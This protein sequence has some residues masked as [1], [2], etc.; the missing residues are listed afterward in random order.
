MD[1]FL[2]NAIPIPVF[3]KDTNGCYTGINKAFSDLFNLLEKDII[4]KSVFDIH[5]KELA[6]VYHEKDQELLKRK[7]KQVS[8]SQVKDS[9][10]EI[11][12]VIFNKAS[13]EDENNNIIGLIGVILDIT[14]Q[15]ILTK[16]RDEMTNK[17]NK[18]FEQ[19]INLLII[20]DFQGKIIELNSAVKKMF[21]YEAEDMIGKS[22]LEYLHPE[23]MDKTREVMQ[24]L[25]EGEVVHYFENRYRHCDGSYRTLAWSANSEVKDQLMFI[26]AQDITEVKLQNKALLE[27]SKLAAMGEMIGNIAHQW[28]QPLSVIST[29]AT[30]M[31]IQNEY[32]LLN[33]ETINKT[34]DAINNNAQY[35][36]KTI[37]DFRN[38][39]KGDRIKNIFSVTDLIDSS[40]QLLEGSLKS[41]D[42]SI[43]L[44]MKDDLKING[45]QN[46]LTQCIINIVN[47]A[48]D[49]LDE[50]ALKKKY[51]FITTQRISNNIVIKIVD[52]AGGIPKLLQEKIFEPYFTTKH[53]KQGT[54]LGLS[55]TYKLIVDGMNGTI[56]SNNVHYRH[57]DKSYNGAEFVITLPI[58]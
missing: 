30:G 8:E 6:L 58:V 12:D 49:A 37:D 19:S 21:G 18:F 4:G 42:I 46:E 13:I 53:K 44:D 34:C 7:S 45:Y 14:E 9:H 35:L 54:G 47:N 26:S 20:G 1:H 11:H 39:I 32:N 2:L 16:Q 51:I 43:V 27:Q 38:F 52:N 22:F 15:N 29:G 3:Y 48:K 40:L 28:R 56:T 33:D 10:G 55:M 5:P 25:S 41:S 57:N 36:S 23:D 24:K 50:L 31:K 17:A